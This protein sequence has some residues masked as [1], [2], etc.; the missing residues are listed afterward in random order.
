MRDIFVDCVMDCLPPEMQVDLSLTPTG[1][2]TYSFKVGALSFEYRDNTVS[3][4]SGNPRADAL[5]AFFGNDDIPLSGGHV[6]LKK[7]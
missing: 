6:N 1:F 5:R 4:P 7:K 3:P 2:N